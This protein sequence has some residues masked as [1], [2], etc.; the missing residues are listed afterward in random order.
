MYSVFSLWNQIQAHTYVYEYP[1]KTVQ[2]VHICKIQWENVYES[3]NN[4]DIRN[5]Y[6][7]TGSHVK[8]P[9]WTMCKLMSLPIFSYW[10]IFY[11][12]IGASSSLPLANEIYS[13]LFFY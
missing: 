10:C 9:I 1:S 4:P 11:I 5:L 7:N 3:G 2:L 12:H 13:H 6:E 8:I